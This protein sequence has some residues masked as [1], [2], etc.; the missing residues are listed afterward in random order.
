VVASRVVLPEGDPPRKDAKVVRDTLL[1]K[2]LEADLLAAAGLPNA[3]RP[4]VD[5][6]NVDP[7]PREP[8][9][10]V[11]MVLVERLDSLPVSS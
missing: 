3:D 7:L 4:N 1:P 8:F 6:P 5:P 11:S 10:P 2:G 9:V